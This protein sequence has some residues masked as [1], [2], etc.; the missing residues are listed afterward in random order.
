[1]ARTEIIVLLSNCFYC[2]VS[3]SHKYFASIC[4]LEYR[5]HLLQGEELLVSFRVMKICTRSSQSWLSTTKIELGDTHEFWQQE[6]G[7][8]MQ[9]LWPS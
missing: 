6:L 7:K 8:E 9:L 4:L 5:V 2:G 3:H 1:V